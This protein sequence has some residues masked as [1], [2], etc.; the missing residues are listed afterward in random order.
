MLSLFKRTFDHLAIFGS[1]YSNWD[2]FG[3]LNS[4]FFCW[5]DVWCSFSDWY[6]TCDFA[7][8]FFLLA[9]PLPLLHSPDSA[10][11]ATVA[12]AAASAAARLFNTNCLE[13][14]FE[15]IA[16]TGCNWKL[17][18]YGDDDRF[19]DVWSIVKSL[20]LPPIDLAT[21]FKLESMHPFSL[22]PLP[23]PQKPPLGCCCCFEPMR[24]SPVESWATTFEL[25]KSPIDLCRW[26]RWTAFF[27][28]V[29]PGDFTS[30]C[31]PLLLSHA[32]DF[33][34]NW[35]CGWLLPISRS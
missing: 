4:H 27:E 25:S 30:F 2:S 3:G 26:R 23:V 13:L 20:R 12:A 34:L 7:L 1:L 33:L 35:W 9:L 14:P 24:V 8:F 10:D 6:S 16:S 22:L 19:V 11:S 28:A 21:P 5:L 17:L 31:S 18:A 15:W 32:F 29:T